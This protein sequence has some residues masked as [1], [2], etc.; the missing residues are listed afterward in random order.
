ML[1]T[2]ATAAAGAGAQL[3]A[4]PW[5]I[6]FSLGIATLLVNFWAFRLEYRNVLRNAE[7]LEE[8]LVEVDRIR[9]EQGLPPNAQALREAVQ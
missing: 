5:Q 1:V 8:V 9:A 2:I 6:H 4:W 7:T 3:K